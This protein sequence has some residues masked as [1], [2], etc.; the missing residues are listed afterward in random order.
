ME[1]HHSAEVLLI[2]AIGDHDDLQADVGVVFE[3]LGHDVS[4]E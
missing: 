4:E 1:S 2:G 3:Q